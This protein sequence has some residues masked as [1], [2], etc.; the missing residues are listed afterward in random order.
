MP[1]TCKYPQI[2][3]ASFAKEVQGEFG[4]DYLIA[5]TRNAGKGLFAKRQ[6]K[7]GDIIAEY[8]GRRTHSVPHITTHLL[9]VPNSNL[10][11]DGRELSDLLEY[12]SSSGKYWPKDNNLDDW[13]RG[14][15]AIAN[16]S[17][18]PNAKMK[19]LYDDLSKRDAN[20]SPDSQTY[21]KG[22]D[23]LPRRPFLVASK[24]IAPKEEITW[25]YKVVFDDD[26]YDS[27]A[28]EYENYGI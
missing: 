21:F 27:D 13:F 28:T 26:T 20:Y 19:F 1:P 15:A 3:Y 22:Q 10:L 16:S 5:N 4:R 7:K 8:D 14:Y 18:H 11:I 2:C 24:D 17:K 6:F 25:K 9:R 23:L 12:D